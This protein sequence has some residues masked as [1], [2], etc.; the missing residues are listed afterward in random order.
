MEGFIID[1]NVGNIDIRKDILLD[2]NKCLIMF[3]EE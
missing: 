1:D 3:F 2:L